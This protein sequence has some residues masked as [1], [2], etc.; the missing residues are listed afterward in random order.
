MR[1]GQYALM[2]LATLGCIVGQEPSGRQK[3][4]PGKLDFTFPP[5]GIQEQK[6]QHRK[7]D[8]TFTPRLLRR[9]RLIAGV[10]LSPSVCSSL[11]PAQRSR[12]GMCGKGDELSGST[13][14]PRRL[15]QPS[16]LETPSPCSIPLLEAPI[17]KNNDYTIRQLRPRLGN[18][19]PMPTV[20]PPAPSCAEKK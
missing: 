5:L 2:S 20:K 4:E 14:N 15:W 19:A 8:F 11:S 9:P 3:T 1:L 18:L 12:N 17:P 6:T 13:V 16:Q 7:L 10:S